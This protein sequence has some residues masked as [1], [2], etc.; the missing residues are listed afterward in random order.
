MRCRKAQKLISVRFDGELDALRERSMHAHLSGC[1]RCQRFAENLPRGARPLQLLRLPLPR[2]GFQYRLMARLPER[3]Q[4]RDW[5]RELL[6][7]LT[8]APVAVGAGA[9]CLGVA[10]A[11]LTNGEQRTQAAQRSDPTETLYAECFTAIPSESAGAKYLALIDE[12]GR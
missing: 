5:L 11:V 6:D 9:L 4:R 3:P 1:S 2:P 12:T 10:L 8:P 7:V